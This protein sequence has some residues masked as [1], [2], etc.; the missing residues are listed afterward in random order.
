MG[1]AYPIEPVDVEPV[2][3]AYRTIQTPI[4]HPDSVVLLEKLRRIEPLCMEGQP[5]IVWDRAEG[6]TIYDAWGNRWIDFSSGVL[7]TNAGHGR[8]QM[9]D[10]VVEQAR[11]GLLT[12][13]CFPN[14]ARGELV[15]ALQ[16]VAPRPD[17]KV[18]LMSTGSEAIEMS[19]KLARE[20]SRRRGKAD[21]VFVSFENAF[22][23]RTLGAQLAVA[24]WV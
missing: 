20:H 13:Y 3:T 19:I 24:S 12:S 21:S 4:P 16:K 14:D 2:E 9:I 5:P 22:H 11:H 18:M 10:A 7:I 1:E 23:G 6:A 17:D 15:E 8:R